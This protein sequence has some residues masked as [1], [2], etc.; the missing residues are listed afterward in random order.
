MRLLVLLILLFVSAIIAF[1]LALYS[2]TR[3]VGHL[4]LYIC[5]LSVIVYAQQ[6]WEYIKERFLTRSWPRK[7]EKKRKQELDQEKKNTFSA[8]FFFS[9]FYSC[10]LT[11]LFSFI[12]SHLS[13]RFIGTTAL[14][15]TDDDNSLI[16][17]AA[18]AAKLPLKL[19]S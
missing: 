8:Q 18:L 19:H 13:V 4:Y 5:I 17:D 1:L 6:R 3:C 2:T 10:F 14:L 16:L 7:K 9:F 11:F 12:N 15:V